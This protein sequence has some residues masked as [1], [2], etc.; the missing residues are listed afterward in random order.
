MGK[1]FAVV[2]IIITLI[3]TAVFIFH[4]QLLWMPE[5]ISTH[6]HGIDHQ[7]M[8]TMT[9]SGVL[10]VLSQV[11]LGIFVW[12]SSDQAEG[13]KIK[14]FPGGPT[15]M[16]V[17]AIV[18]VGVEILALS[19]VGSKVWAGIYLSPPDPKAMTIDV[20]AG[21][22]AFY[23]RYPGA[24]GKFGG[25]HPDKIDEGNGNFFGLDPANDVAARDDIVV[26][27][28]VIPV[29]RPIYLTMHSKDV[30]HS[31]YVRELRLQQDIVP[32]LLIP[33]HF[34]AT[35]TGKFE[36]V[37]TQLCGLGHS[38]MRAYLEVMPEDQ[39]DQWMKQKIAEQ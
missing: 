36:I 18:L 10:F 35:K 23:F 26:A 15:P 8:E 28:M 29:N 3:S 16:V 25:L 38:N 39:F 37:C 24:D 31:F 22:F 7:L 14:T 20:Q 30:I 27:S 6:G 13:R 34:T 2:L 12:Q 1:A 5:D 9:A 21:Q 32:G 33:L 17:S 4:G 19:F 11:L